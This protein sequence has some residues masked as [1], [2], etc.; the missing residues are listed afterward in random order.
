VNNSARIG[1]LGGT[2]DPIHIGHL[3]CAEEARCQLD[4]DKVIFMVAGKPAFKDEADITSAEDRYWMTCTATAD[5]PYFEVSR[6][7][8]DRKGTTYTIDTLRELKRGSASNAELFF[9]TGSDTLLEILSWK[10]VA[11]IADLATFIVAARPG[12]DLEEIRAL[13][14]KEAANFRFETI[15]VPALDVS[16]SDLRRRFREGMPVRYLLTE[17]VEHFVCERGLY[18]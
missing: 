8:I 10:D 3:V 11:E 14:E 16:S 18:C 15:E 12:Y 9:I 1:I 17:E 5:N 4:L 13:H 6:L 7:E 2:F